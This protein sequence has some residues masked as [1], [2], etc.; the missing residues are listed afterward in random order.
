[1]SDG[2]PIFDI[3]LFAM[4]AAFLALRLRSVL[5]RR[6]GHER[7][8]SDPLATARRQQQEAPEK[9][10]KLPKR[11]RAAAGATRA[12][13]PLAAGLTQIKVADPAFDERHFLKGARAAFEMIIGAF[14]V[15]DTGALRPLLSDEV[16]DNFNRAIKERFDNKETL[17]TT[18]VGIKAS[19]ILEARMEDR[20][21][22]VTVKFVS[23]QVNVTRD[24]KGE[25]VDGDPAQVSEVVDIWTFARDTRARDPNW[26][27]VA[28]RTP[29]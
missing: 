20:M 11:G 21:A 6:T 13:T 5:G 24:A 23:E 8:R 9:V 1:M 12:E 15:G 7:R 29:N 26:V 28:T 10:V 3:I 22:V 19:E 27:L 4:I 16:Y 18:L 25:I 17:E 14:A 2:F